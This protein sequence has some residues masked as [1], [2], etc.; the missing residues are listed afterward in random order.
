MSGDKNTRLSRIPTLNNG[1]D[2]AVAP[3]KQAAPIPSKSPLNKDASSLAAEARKYISDATSENT[4]L[5]YQ[6]DIRHFEREWGGMLPCS[7]QKI[8]EYLTCYAKVHK[9]ATLARRL[10]AL[11]E[12]HTTACYVDPTKDKAVRKAMKGIR[13]NHNAPQ[14]QARPLQISELKLIVSYLQKQI[15]DASEAGLVTA[16]QERKWLKAHR[17]MAILLIGFWR[18]FRSATIC[19]LKLE[20]MKLAT[21]VINGQRVESVRIFLPASK[22][23]RQAKGE[24][25]N[26]PSRPDLCPVIAYKNWLLAAELEK[27]KGWLFRKF[28]KSGNLTEEKVLPGSLNHWMKRLC[29]AAGISGSDEFSSHSMRRGLASLLA[30]KGADV[31]LLMQHVGWKSHQSA[32]RYVSDSRSKGDELL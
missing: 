22:G 6:S 12:W 27:E 19:N 16:R 28:D 21:M 5:A 14:D 29:K 25:F 11:S 18:G 9:V 8:V 3:E 32:V 24:T 20:H 23:D 26:M 2:Q 30:E 13:R 4:R 10:A 31:P 17:D 15:D 1:E 7:A